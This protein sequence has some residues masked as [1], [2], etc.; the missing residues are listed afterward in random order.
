MKE[1]R[2]LLTSVCLLLACHPSHAQEWSVAT[3]AADWINLGTLNAEGSVAT[4]RHTTLNVSA[5]YNPWTFQ[6]REGAQMQN[7]RQ[8]YAVG[9]R[10]WPWY[11]YSGWWAGAKLQ[12]EEYNRGGILEQS[13][14]EGDAVGAGISAG[15]T[16]MVHRNFNLEFGAGIWGGW[17]DYT[18]YSCPRCGRITESGQKWFIAPNEILLSLVFIF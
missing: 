8:T 14:E 12:Y 15:Y 6:D 2:T 4:G 11:V 10:F 17:K 16:L 9:V 7:R 18:V 13:T 1:L 3:N 5:R